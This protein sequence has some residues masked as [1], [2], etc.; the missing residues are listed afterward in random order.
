VTSFLDGR[1]RFR[2]LA[3]DFVIRE[4]K[5]EDFMVRLSFLVLENA[6]SEVRLLWGMAPRPVVE[7]EVFLRIERGWGAV[8]AWDC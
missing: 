3:C 6:E 4:R 8:G 5:R 2:G 7:E 1:R